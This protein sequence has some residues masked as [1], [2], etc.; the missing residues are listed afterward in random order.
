MSP[1]TTLQNFLFKPTSALSLA[2]LRILY[3]AMMAFSL[4]RFMAQGWVDKVLVEPSFFFKFPGFEW[5]VVWSPAGLYAQFT[6]TALLAILVSLGLFYRFAIVAFLLSFSY[7]QLLD[8]TLYLNHYYL[9][10]MAGLLFS[11]VPTHSQ[12]SLDNLRKPQTKQNYLPAWM[13]YVFRFQ[14]AVVYFYAALAKAQ[15]DWLLHAQPLNIWLQARTGTPIIGPIL[16]HP[17]APLAA[18]WTGFL[19][20]LTIWV[21]LLVPKTRKPAYLLVLVFHFFTWVFFEI[22]MFPIIMVVLTTSFFAGHW[23]HKL[24]QRA[25]SSRGASSQ[26]KDLAASPEAPDSAALRWTPLRR[27]A[28]LALGLHLGFQALFPLRHYLYPG[29]VLWNEQGMRFAWKVMMREKN[30][31]ITYQVKQ[32]STGKVWEVTPFD[33]LTWRQFSDMSS[34]PDLIVQLGKHIAWDFQQKGHGPVEVRVEAWVSLN[35][36]KPALL[37]DPEVDIN[38]VDNS[39]RPADWLLPMPQQTP[40]TLV[41]TSSS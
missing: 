29:D 41:R 12:L 32:K 17:W 24:L 31:S 36:R 23:P 38:R 18:S 30:G 26:A 20:D 8:I 34:Q 1:A 40:P 22:G 16:G 35:G 9:V 21:W 5:T 39:W 10:V 2:V 25:K 14:V 7:L 27:F 3:G 28:A 19:Y 37:I 11:I 4:I 33:Y 6:I 13:L 15:P